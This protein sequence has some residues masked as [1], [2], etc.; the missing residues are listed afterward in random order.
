MKRLNV[1]INFTDY[2]SQVANWKWGSVGL[3]NDLA[4]NRRQAIS[5][6]MVS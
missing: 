6:P 4:L 1:D 3:D 2:L 5:E